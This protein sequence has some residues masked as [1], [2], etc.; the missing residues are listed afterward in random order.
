MF[1]SSVAAGGAFRL[2]FNIG[3]S[4]AN[5]SGSLALPFGATMFSDQ[6]ASGGVQSRLAFN[7]YPLA[8][9]QSSGIIPNLQLSAMDSSSVVITLGTAGTG[10]AFSGSGATVPVARIELWRVHSINE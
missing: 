6:T 2:V 4:A 7:I 5:D 9:G 3:L 1:S 10:A 8:G